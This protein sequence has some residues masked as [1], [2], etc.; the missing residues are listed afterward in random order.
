[1]TQ[2]ERHNRGIHPLEEE[3][4]RIL[5]E[6][7]ELPHLPPGVRAVVQR[8]AHAT[9]DLELAR[10]MVLDEEA[11]DAGVEAIRAGR[12]VVAD[13]EMVRRGIT[14]C[15]AACYLDQAPSDPSP[16]PTRSAAAMAIA[17]G[18]HAEGAVFV[19]GCAPTALLAVLKL[20]RDGLLSPCLVVGT[21]VGFVGAAA[22]KQ[23]ARESGLRTITNVGEK[24]GSAVAAAAVNAIARIAR[25]GEVP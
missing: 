16:W 11:I 13:V 7:L 4:Y 15:A 20:H 17:A 8:V 6:R 18:H 19:V 2:T 5:A 12:P 25:S 14:G 9:A 1:V 22:S 21:P 23:D 3:S 24:G 10:S